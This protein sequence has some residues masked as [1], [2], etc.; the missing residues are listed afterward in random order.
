MSKIILLLFLFS[1]VTL[2]E[3]K[4][5]YLK[6]TKHCQVNDAHIQTAATKLRKSTEIETAKNIYRAVQKY[7]E[8]ERYSDTKRGAVKTLQDKKGNCAD[9]AHLLVALFRAAGIPA[10]YV[11]APGHYW[12]QCRVGDKIYDCDPTSSKHKFGK[13]ADDGK[14]PDR[15]MIEL[16]S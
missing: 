14:V 15:Y 5:D 8:Y 16:K 4:E 12:T 9:Q 7:I 3:T 2:K 13:R 1:F 10:R 11:H 6:P